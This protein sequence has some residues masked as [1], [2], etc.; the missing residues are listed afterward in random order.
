M[1]F[2]SIILLL[3]SRDFKLNILSNHSDDLKGLVLFIICTIPSYIFNVIK[4]FAKQIYLAP[5]IE[6]M[7]AKNLD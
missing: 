7:K 6:V 5:E 1:T 2:Y 4:I 3:F